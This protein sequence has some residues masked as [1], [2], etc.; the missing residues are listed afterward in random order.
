[1]FNRR[2]RLGYLCSA[3]GVLTAQ[4]L[5]LG[6]QRAPV[7][8]NAT[9]GQ[10]FGQVPRTVLNERALQAGLPFQWVRDINANGAVDARELA[11]LWGMGESAE[12]WTTG[13]ELT[14]GFA[15]SYGQLAKEPVTP[16][17]KRAQLVHEELRQGLPTVVYTDLSGAP[18]AD[19]A[20]VEQVAEVARR[21]ERVFMSQ[22]GSIAFV[23]RAAKLTGA[24]KALFYRNQSPWCMGPST[25]GKP[26]CG[27]FE[28]L[29]P[30]VSGLYPSDLQKDKGFC[31][32]LSKHADA[33]RLLDRHTA[34][35]RVDGQLVSVPFSKAFPE[36]MGAVASSLRDL[37]KLLQDPADRALRDY[38]T[39]AAQAFENDD[40]DAADRAWLDV[41][42][43]TSRWY[44]RIGPD[45][46]APSYDPCRRKAAF[47]LSFGRFDRRSHIWK[48]KFALVKD[49]MEAKMA[50]L[51]GAPYEAR[52]VDLGIPDFVDI[53]L[54][55]GETRRPMGAY[56][57]HILPNAGAVA[58]EGRSRTIAF[59]NLYSDLDSQD[60]FN[61]ASKGYFCE[62][63]AW[64]FSARPNPRIVNSIF[65]IAGLNLGPNDEY[66][67][68]GQLAPEI[69]GGT[70]AVTLKQIKGQ[71]SALHF[72]DWLRSKELIEPKL[73]DTATAFGLFWS[74]SHVSRGVFAGDGRRSVH[75][76]V[77]AVIIAALL[78]SGAI[79]W[80]PAASKKNEGCLDVD[81]EAV[82]KPIEK[83]LK[84]V[85]QI[86]A[87]GDKEALDGLIKRYV[88]EGP[89]D[90]FDFIETQGRRQP[91]NTFLY[92]FRLGGR[93]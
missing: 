2:V 30:R 46:V 52:D 19:R 11:V 56:I 53:I 77:G 44:L 66:R 10:D 58:E 15:D 68:R 69:F 62:E 25:A 35:R 3:V 81:I 64:K 29:P 51:A 40:W 92:A 43:L 71:T 26:G 8:Q 49:K 78:E 67:V 65:H 27:A 93:S 48:Q 50:A 32:A 63:S 17:G 24:D 38:A 14:P 41:K 86:K 80:R 84:T 37:A 55:A 88:D 18:A 4:A 83:L 12:K 16:A 34:V 28:A 57:G 82:A 20:I 33:R 47:Q 70:L 22:I 59:T 9:L 79:V 54:N 6:C 21:L 76:H 91:S 5:V 72:I 90:V 60:R 31:E 74:I 7:P 39:A 61:K 73:A 89:K 23:E 75:G 87:S 13:Q 42:T 45:R 85:A 1:M 36:A